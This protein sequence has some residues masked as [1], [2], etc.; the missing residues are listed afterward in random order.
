M[1]TARP[2]TTALH[3]AATIGILL[4]CGWAQ[5]VS[6]QEP[7]GGGDGWWRQWSPLAPMGDLVRWTAP[8]PVFPLVT[9]APAP[10]VGLAWTAGN[11]AALTRDAADGHTEFRTATRE[12]RGGYRRP[13]DPGQTSSFLGSATGWRPVGDAGG[14][15]GGVTIERAALAGGAYAALDEPHGMTPH[16][17]AD[18]S[19]T[20]LGRT[21]ARLEGA[22][23]WR[24][25]GWGLGLGLGYQ[26]W[27]TRTGVSQVPRFRY[28]S[29]AG[30]SV[31]V[32][33]DL[34]SG[35]ATVG[36]HARWR[37]EVHRL[38]LFT[39]LAETTVFRFE[40]Y[41]EPTRAHIG[42]R[43]VPGYSRRI[44]REGMAAALSAEVRV[45]GVRGVAFG[46][47]SS[48][49]ERQFERLNVNDPPTDDW[50]TRGRA[51]GIAA[52]AGSPEGGP[53]IVAMLRWSSVSGEAMRAGL[54]EEG[55]LFEADESVLDGALHLRFEPG[56][57]WKTGAH[58]SIVREDRTRIDRLAR[59]RSSVQAWRPALAVEAARNLNDRFTLGAGAGLAWYT[60]SGGIPDPSHRGE[61]YRAWIGPELAYLAT[62]SRTLA[63]VGSLRWLR[64]GGQALSLEARYDQAAARDHSPI[65]PLTPSGSRSAWNL[66]L[67]W[68]W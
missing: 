30:A 60:P 13:L 68:S 17:L 65:L 52:E 20:D 38:T 12:E 44:H 61:R 18:S 39:R 42:H 10:R 26:S 33:R 59:V 32:T 23:G 40:G 56:A 6:A 35:R 28:G 15:S 11:P 66:V 45:A 5:P 41:G 36:A 67:R 34:A 9:V 2:G 54:E 55:V 24:L 27:D 58:L 50:N 43:A 48:L 53:Q 4:Y 51:A 46:E 37:S 7:A 3:R 29:R 57:G 22:G 47:A 16:S 14:V 49:D 21:L 62:P 63:G 64:P 1:K 25:G 19:G 31:G 8:T